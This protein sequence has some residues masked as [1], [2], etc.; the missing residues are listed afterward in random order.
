MTVK[1]TLSCSMDVTET[2]AAAS[3]PASPS[4]GSGNTRR[5]TEYNE[6]NKILDGSTTPAAD[7][8]VDLSRTLAA[9]SETQDLTAAAKASDIAS[10]VDLTGKKLVGILINAASTN[11][12]S[13]LTIS[14]AASNGYNLFGSASGQV[15]LFPGMTLELFQNGIAASLQAVAAGAKDITFA[16][17]VADKVEILA[18][19]G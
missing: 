18:I 10:T 2:I 8:V 5:F 7:T 14:P 6:V 17:T 16:G 19:F 9:A 11:N 1:A 15:T 13:G 4:D 12:A 3:S